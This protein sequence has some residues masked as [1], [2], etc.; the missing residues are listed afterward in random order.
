MR[1]LSD[2]IHHLPF[3]DFAFTGDLKKDAKSYIEQKKIS[4]SRQNLD[5]A[6]YVTI[7]YRLGFGKNIT[8]HTLTDGVIEK[9]KHTKIE[10]VPKGIPKFMKQPFLIEARHDKMLFD[11][12]YSIGGFTIDNEI[13]LLIGTQLEKEN[14]YF[15]QHEKAS[16]DGRKI[17]D[18][19][20]VYNAYAGSIYGQPLIQ[21][22]TRKDTF[23]FVTILSL[24]LEAE[25]TPLIIESKIKNKKDEPCNIKTRTP[26]TEWITKRIYIDKNIKYNNISNEHNNIDKNGKY[27][28]DVTVTGHLRKQ[29]YGKEFSK[30]KWIY[31][32][33]YDST[34]WKSDKDTKII[35]DIYDKKTK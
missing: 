32:E 20:L 18:I 12:I 17:D 3:N 8:V 24:M 16:F 1:K 31:I 22:K 19:N 23:A 34:R 26:E 2:I 4:P 13:C 21:L 7:F 11:D 10:N 33:S 14:G 27:I 9:I 6:L 30:E 29:R 35:V 28:K 15:C 25:K 5:N